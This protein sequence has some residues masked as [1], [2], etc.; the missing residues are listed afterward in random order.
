PAQIWR[1]TT[2]GAG[3]WLEVKLQDAG[4]N[5]NG[6]GSWIEVRRNGVTQR[7]EITV[8]GGHV[9]GEAGWWHF[10]L[11]DETKA[12]ARVIWP[13]G[14]PSEWG[15]VEADHFYTLTRD[16]PPALWQPPEMA[17]AN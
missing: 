6:V 10:G 16:A 9:S 5:V 17:A 12:E 1:N 8:G 7:R 11:G 13:D 3:H 2:A 15:P 4:A 14:K